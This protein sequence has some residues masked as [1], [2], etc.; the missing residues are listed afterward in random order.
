MN[1][2]TLCGRSDF[3]ANE[4]NQWTITKNNQRRVCRGWFAIQSPL[5]SLQHKTLAD[6]LNSS[7]AARKCFGDLLIRPGQTIDIRFQ[8]NLS[9]T[10]LLAGPCKFPD[11]LA[12]R[13]TLFI[14][15]SDE[16][17]LWH[18]EPSM[19]QREVSR[20]SS[21]FSIDWNPKFPR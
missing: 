13:F 17:L 3:S 18:R 5:I 11:Y 20:S 6:L 12:A 16:I 10:H 1:Y 15:E 2:R 7:H 21:D 14:T 8:K 9:A 19:A 4:C